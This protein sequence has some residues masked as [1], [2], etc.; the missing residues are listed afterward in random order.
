MIKIPA[1][2][3][4]TSYRCRP[5]PIAVPAIITALLRRNCCDITGRANVPPGVPARPA[6]RQNMMRAAA[7]RAKIRRA[8]NH[9]ITDRGRRPETGVA[10][11]ATGSPGVR[12][13]LAA[14][15]VSAAVDVHD[16]ARGGGEPVG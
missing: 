8:A 3:V 15:R 7:R 14:D 9:E 12:G 1:V 13:R 10:E 4:T 16:L 11:V 5:R 6:G 2:N